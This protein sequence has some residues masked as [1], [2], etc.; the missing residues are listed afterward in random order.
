MG[1]IP[2]LVLII[3]YLD[4]AQILIGLN[5][6][7]SESIGLQSDWWGS[8]RYCENGLTVISDNESN[9]EKDNHHPL[10]FMLCGILAFRNKINE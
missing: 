9:L 4:L 1:S 8:V 7:C 3:L 5:S 2:A 10:L 6:D